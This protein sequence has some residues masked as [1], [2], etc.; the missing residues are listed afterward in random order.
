MSRNINGSLLS[1]RHPLKGSR[2]V[3]TGGVSVIIGTALL[4]AILA[5]GVFGITQIS[6]SALSGGAKVVSASGATNGLAVKFGSVSPTPTPT[7][8]PVPTVTPSATPVPPANGYTVVGNLIKNSSGQTVLLHGL[9]RPSL[10]W[11]CTGESVNN[12]GSGIPA[13]DFATM[14]TAWNADAVR[15]PVSEDR[16]LPGTADSC[17]TYQATVESAVS[18]V[19]AQG[20]IAI[21]DLHWS[22]QGNSSNAS[23]Q[24]CMPDA[25]STTFWQQIASHYKGNPNVWFE[26]YN[27]PYPSGGWSV[28]EN[29]GSVTCSALV[30]GKT[31]TWNAP[32]MQSLVNTVRATGATNIVIAGGLAYS[33][34]LNGAPS[35]TGGNVAYAIHIYRQSGSSFSS[36]GWSS[37]LGTTP[38]KSPVISTEFGDQVCDGQTFDQQLLTFFH[39]NN[40]GYTGW[41]WFVSGCSFP[42]LITDA[43]GDC[44]GTAQGCAVQADMKKQPNY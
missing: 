8:T 30:G 12:T 41:A 3:V 20:M 36:A 22:D 25:N 37:Q 34:N 29:G 14:K 27:E 32:G 19:L 1:D 31:A 4:V 35:L 39:A 10:E 26:L 24:Q 28:W 2:A 9:D 15:I 13:S 33:S 42:S 38:T 21:V 23:G 16:W 6:A 44:N 18:E 40:I 7:P 11:S 5:S 17:S 43:A